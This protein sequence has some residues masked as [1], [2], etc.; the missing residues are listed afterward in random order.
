MNTTE[1]NV[2][3]RRTAARG[4]LTA[5]QEKALRMRYGVGAEPGDDI[6]TILHELTPEAAGAVLAIEERALKHGLGDGTMSPVALTRL[7]H[8]KGARVGDGDAVSE[9][10]RVQVAGHDD[11]ARRHREGAH[12]RRDR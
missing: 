6:D 4:Q 9:A 2:A 12:R 7:T 5:Q 1:A 3:I 11:A 10:L 8:G